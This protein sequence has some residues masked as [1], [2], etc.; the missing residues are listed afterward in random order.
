LEGKAMKIVI[1]EVKEE[2]VICETDEATLRLPRR[3]FPARVFPG[4]VADYEDGQVT[5]WDEERQVDEE[6]LSMLF[7]MLL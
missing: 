5:M 6:Q 3:L 4:D 1:G 2:I 7:K